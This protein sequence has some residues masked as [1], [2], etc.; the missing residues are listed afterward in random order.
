MPMVP[1]VPVLGV[2]PRLLRQQFELFSSAHR[3]HGDVFRLRLGGRS[4]S[5]FCHPE[6]AEEL[7]ITKA[8]HFNK[9]GSFWDAARVLLGQG[10]VVSEGEV[11]RR[12]RRM[13]QPQFHAERLGALTQVITNSLA[14]EL[15]ELAKPDQ[16][17]A[18]VDEWASRAILNVLLV[19]MFG[20]KMPREQSNELR[21]HLYFVLSRF[22]LGMV[23]NGMPRWLPMPGRRRYQRAQRA[24]DQQIQALIDAR[25]RQGPG[26]GDLLDLMYAALDH[27]THATM[28]DQQL[29]DEIVNMFVAGYETTGAALAWTMWLLA[30][31]PQVMARLQAEVDEQLQ[32]RPPRFADLPRLAYAKQIYQEALRLYPSSFWVPRMALG[33]VEI[34]GYPLAAGELVATS[35]YCIHRHPQLWP[36]PDRFDPNRFAPGEQPQRHRLAWM[37]FGAGQRVCVGRGLSILQAQLAL[38]MLAQRFE[39]EP[40]PGHAPQPKISTTMTSKA[41]IYLQVRGRGSA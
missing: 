14:E 13:I 10:L 41:G 19:S 39:F 28:S 20:T 9:G 17:L 18:R 37:P 31:H 40:A 26:A 33:P 23:T 8:K 7:L 27:E 2:I 25:R 3:E 36:N 21:E 11:W 4:L 6:M 29:R 16:R 35:T 34:G 22:V 38:V 15:A 30:N 5:V 32:G 24:I 12:Q 1:G